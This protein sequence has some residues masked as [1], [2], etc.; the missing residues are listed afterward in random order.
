MAKA[1][2]SEVRKITFGKRKKGSPQSLITNIH[3]VLRSIVVKVDNP[4]IYT[5][6]SFTLYNPSQLIEKAPIFL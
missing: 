5:S 6:I 1:K 2:G 4:L 3:H